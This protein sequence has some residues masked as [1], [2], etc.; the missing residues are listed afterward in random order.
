MDIKKVVVKGVIVLVRVAGGGGGGGGT[1]GR[2]RRGDWIV[3]RGVA[4]N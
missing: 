2:N 1:G 4:G 3:G